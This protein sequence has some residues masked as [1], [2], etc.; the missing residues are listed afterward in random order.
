MLGAAAESSDAF[1]A[2]AVA[3]GTAAR[4]AALLAGPPPPDSGLA[5]NAL[6]ALGSLAESGPAGLEAALAAGVAAAAVARCTPAAHL[7]L[8]EAALDLLC[9]LMA[10]G[11]AEGGGAAARAAAG[12][13][14]AVEALAA[15]LAA[16]GGGASPAPPG[17]VEVRMLLAL[18]MLCSNSPERQ[19][20]LATAPGA[21]G[22][23]LALMRCEDDADS[24]QVAAGLFKELGTSP[25]LA[26]RAALKR[27]VEAASGRAP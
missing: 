14:G 5:I 13:A 4:L 25:T 11:A 16:R 6:G 23:L 26:V 15:L 22:R 10:S 1:A 27:G 20:A 17:E 3:A 18:G 9:K 2:E 7:T 8:Q 19:L 21:V 12:D 24:Q